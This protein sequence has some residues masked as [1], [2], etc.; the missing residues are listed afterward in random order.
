MNAL[1][2]LGSL[3]KGGMG[4]SAGRL[5]RTV[6]N[7][8]F[9]APGGTYG[10]G[11]GGL[12]GGSPGG[13]GSI[14]DMLGKLAG[15]NSMQ[16][17]SPG[18][19]A[20]SIIDMLGK[21]AGGTQGGAPGAGRGSSGGFST[22]DLLG[23]LGKVVLGGSGGS[24]NSSMGAGANTIFGALAAQALALA[25]SMM[26]GDKSAAGSQ[27]LEVDDAT[28]VIAGLR[29]PANAREEQQVRDVATLTVQAMI[30]AAK[31]DGR[32]DAEETER[33]VGKMQ[34]DGVTDEEQRFVMEEM[35]KPMDTDAI[36]RAVPNQQVAAQIYAASLMAIEV[37]TD[38]EKRYMQELASKLGL[39]QPVLAYMHQAVGLA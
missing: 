28:A 5:D 9:G 11:S 31:A 23:S 18:G 1:D 34:E 32:I 13:G 25:K 12:Q 30:N 36:V 10:G 16:G 35:R 4:S 6:N 26:S 15:G 27:S 8:G 38:A 19:G 21:L 2:I 22:G 3:M 7:T 20:G 24:G 33:L 37:D 39:S 14:L 17:G 29:K